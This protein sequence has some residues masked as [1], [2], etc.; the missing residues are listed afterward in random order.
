MKLPQTG[1]C[2]GSESDLMKHIYYMRKVPCGRPSRN[3]E[4]NIHIAD[5]LLIHSGKKYGKPL[6]LL[7]AITTIL[8]QAEKRGQSGVRGRLAGFW[9][10]T[11]RR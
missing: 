3:G 6:L 10:I 9:A 2:Y 11:S 5:M 4:Q 7:L 8:H 1:T